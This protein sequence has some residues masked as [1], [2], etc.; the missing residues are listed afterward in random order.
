MVTG[1]PALFVRFFIFAN[2]V[3]DY[4]KSVTFLVENSCTIIRASCP[5]PVDLGYLP[6]SSGSKN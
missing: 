6:V 5:E 1:E 3:P 2:S 4:E